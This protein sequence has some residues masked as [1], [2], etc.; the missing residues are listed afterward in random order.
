MAKDDP[1]K[2][3]HAMVKLLKPQYPYRLRLFLSKDIS[4][5]QDE[6]EYRSKTLEQIMKIEY[7]KAENG[8]ERDSYYRSS[9]TSLTQMTNDLT[10]LFTK[11]QKETEDWDEFPTVLCYEGHE[12]MFTKLFEI[13]YS[14]LHQLVVAYVLQAKNLAEI[15]K[16]EFINGLKAYRVSQP[17]RIKELISTYV[18]NLTT[19]NVWFK[20]LYTASWLYA[21]GNLNRPTLKL[22][23]AIAFWKI[24]L[25]CFGT[26]STFPDWELWLTTTIKDKLFNKTTTGWFVAPNDDDKGAEAELRY[27]LWVNFYDFVFAMQDDYVNK[28]NFQQDDGWNSAL[29]AFVLDFLDLEEVK[30]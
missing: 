28:Y 18:I 27:D 17:S 3:Y 7:P 11:Y 24:F 15:T 1:M 12:A 21:N 19:N 25:S 26:F 9:S 8:E 30:Q 2:Q 10:A 14:P 29:D 20:D 5:I 16:D 23:R 6:W 4:R 22:S 13:E